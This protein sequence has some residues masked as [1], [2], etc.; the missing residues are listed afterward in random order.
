VYQL[1][2]AAVLVYQLVVVAVLVYQLVVVAVLVLRRVS[3]PVF[4]NQDLLYLSSGHHRHPF[5]S[6]NPL[7][8]AGWDPARVP[9]YPR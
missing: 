2:V 1:V 7:L 8:R 4:G 9:E 5:R 3:R 6:Y